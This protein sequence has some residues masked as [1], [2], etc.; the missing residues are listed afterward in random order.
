ME[1]KSQLILFSGPHCELCD[2]AKEL[3]YST[4]PHGS[5][6]LKT[7]DVTSSLWLKKQFGLR[8]PVLWVL[9]ENEQFEGLSELEST[10]PESELCWPFSDLDLADIL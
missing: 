1:S 8:I 9:R 2:Q 5:Y 3:I 7:V 4:L 6:E 10:K